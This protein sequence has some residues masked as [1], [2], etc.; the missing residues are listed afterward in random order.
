MALT[1]FL[2]SNRH[3]ILTRFKGA[4]CAHW[5]ASYWQCWWCLSGRWRWPGECSCL[6]GGWWDQ[7]EVH[8]ESEGRSWW[9]RHEWSD[10]SDLGSWSTRLILQT[11]SAQVSWQVQQRNQCHWSVSTIFKILMPGSVLCMWYLLLKNWIKLSTY[12]VFK[13]ESELKDKKCLYLEETD[14]IPF[15]LS[16]T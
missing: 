4:H 9:P 14:M 2:Q 11:R 6:G 1:K 16:S 15:T 10:D 8:Q 7:H 12:I 3:M 5:K 13:K